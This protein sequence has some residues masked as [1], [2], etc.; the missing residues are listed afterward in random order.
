M[1][2]TNAVSLNAIGFGT[3]RLALRQIG[4]EDGYDSLVVDIGSVGNGCYSAR[5]N[6]N[7]S[8]IVPADGSEF[9]WDTKRWVLVGHDGKCYDI[10]SAIEY[11]S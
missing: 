8:R 11:R 4:S 6:G 3:Y 2:D 7:L 9:S 5:H 10:L 1:T